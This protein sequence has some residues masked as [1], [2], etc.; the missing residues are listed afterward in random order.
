VTHAAVASPERQLFGE[1]AA[2]F[3]QLAS[4]ASR[5]APIATLG[6]VVTLYAANVF[7]AFWML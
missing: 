7:K 5:A 4:A 6:D 3:W 1:F 2:S